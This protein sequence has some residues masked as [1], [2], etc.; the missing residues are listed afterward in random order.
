MSLEFLSNPAVIWF[1]IGLVLLLLEMAVPGLIVM[2]FGVG[3]W[4]TAL[5]T[6]IFHP[7]I[8]T[9]IIIFVITSVIL[10]LLLRKYLKHNFFDKNKNMQDDLDEEFIGKFATAE[11]DFV[12]DAEGKVTFNGTLWSA[13]AESEIKKG[14]KVKIVGRENITFK[15][16]ST[17]N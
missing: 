3:A 8:N 14:E 11:T 12:K 5:I 17:K 15:I 1:F 2:F 16:K 6:A 7:G 9:Q 4:V 10:L 13:I